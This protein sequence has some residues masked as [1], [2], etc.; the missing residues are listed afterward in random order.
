VFVE[1]RARLVA[2]ALT[3]IAF[4]RHLA[5][6]CPCN[7]K[8][9]C[10][11]TVDP[12]G[13]WG[14]RRRVCRSVAGAFSAAIRSDPLRRARRGRPAVELDPETCRSPSNVS[15]PC[16][17]MRRLFREC[18]GSSRGRLQG[19]GRHAIA[20]SSRRG[21]RSRAATP[22]PQAHAES[23][24]PRAPLT[25]RQHCRMRRNPMLGATKSPGGARC[26]VPSPAKCV[27]GTG[28]P[29][30]SGQEAP[31]SVLRTRDQRGVA[32]TAGLVALLIAS[33]YSESLHGA[34]IDR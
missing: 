10:Q 33:A 18:F 21:P 7:I 26:G 3:I 2:R 30:R 27:E 6:A 31:A 20:R 13:V 1:R 15:Q 8:K 9:S 5:S 32:A 4:S 16:R 24:P 34:A 14:S 17:K 25:V 11:C 29:R 19:G 22:A 28:L 23:S 12:L